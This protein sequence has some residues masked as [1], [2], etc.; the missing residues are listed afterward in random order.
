VKKIL[1]A[2]RGEIAVRI[3]RACREM[4]ISPV[5]V[6][7]DC[8]RT[9]LHVRYADEAYPIGP[10]PPGESYLRIDRLIDA[11]RQA[12]ADAIHP[13]YGF[14]AENEDF[15]AACR[16]AG[17]TFIG[18]TPEVIALM[19]NKTA[20][21]ATAR[22]AGVPTVPGTDD[23]VPEGLPG[24][25]KDE[26]DQDESGARGADLRSLGVAPQTVEDDT[27]ASI[28]DRIG[29]PLLVKA[30]AGGGGK[31]MRAVSDPAELAGAIRAARSE[32]R[33]AF[34]DA[35]VYLERQLKHPRH[36]EVQLLGDVQGTVVPFVEREC[37][38]QRR[39]QKVIEETPSLAV[40]PALRAAITSAACAVARAVSYTNAGTIE[41]LLDEDGDFYFLEMNTRLQVE[42][43]VTEMVTGT[44][45][46]RA[47]IRIARGEP[48]DLDP[49]RALAPVGHAIECRIYAE[50]PD[51]NFLPSP[52]R[53]QQ[54]RAPAGPGIRDDSGAAAGL[55]VPI[56][57]D[58][59]IS[60]LIA[61]A[62]DRPRAIARMYRALGEYLVGGIK[63][64][65]PFFRWLLV[66]PEFTQGAFHTTYLDDVLKARNGR[67]F[68]EPL[69]EIEDVAAIAAALRE[70]L[71][72]QAGE[73]RAS[74]ASDSTAQRWKAQARTEGLR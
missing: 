24:N 46:V 34:G 25:G 74:S 73:T 19:G 66:Q 27:I 44:D 60:K 7:S 23:P 69:P 35:A 38:I 45:L 26:R 32:A 37:S 31:G 57:Y 4:G 62:E 63:T 5:A 42:H 17:L 51:N 50:D 30:V 48:L 72:Q 58:P 39:H 14:L 12:R 13:G 68:V 3:S 28:A 2:N 1:I 54:L 71:A 21:R 6:Y 10:S 59:M 33:S 11:A 52:G 20:A 70:V 8:D 18:P 29:Y 61:W 53:I 36:I 55:D 67:P 15:A 41:F 56:F 64:T 16:D 9:S 22:R 65:V 43:P 40:S 49:A 47:Q